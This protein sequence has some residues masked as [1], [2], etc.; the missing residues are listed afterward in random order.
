MKWLSFLNHPHHT[1]QQ[2]LH[3]VIV[4][5]SA[6]TLLLTITLVTFYYIQQTRDSLVEEMITVTKVIANNTKTAVGFNDHIDAQE[7]LQELQSNAAVDAVIIYDVFEEVFVQYARNEQI[8]IQIKYDQQGEYQFKGNHLYISQKIED[9]TGKLGEVHLQ[10]NLAKLNQQLFNALQVI[11]VIFVVSLLISYLLSLRLQKNISTPILKLAKV[12]RDIRESGNYEEYVELSDIAEIDQVREEFNA[13][14]DQISLREEGLKHLASHDVLTKLP[15]RAY[16]TEVLV[17]ALIRGMR[18]S[19][20]HAV[21][22]I[23]L[24]R[25]KNIND[26]LGHSAGDKLLETLSVRLLTVMRG[27]DLLARMGGD[28]FTILLQ[29]V[30][31]ANDAREIAVRIIDV[32]SK[33]FV[34]NDHEVVISPSIGIVMYPDHGATPE[35]LLKNADTAMYIAKSEGGNKYTFFDQ[36]MDVAAKKRMSIEESMRKGV[37]AGEFFLVYQPQISIMD[38]KITGFEALCR[39]QQD[40]GTFVSPVDFIPVAEETGLIID[41]GEMI[42]R[43]AFAQVKKWVESGLLTE[44]VA[45]NIS[46]KQFNQP[47]PGF[48]QLI[49]QLQEEYGLSSEFI[50]LEITEAVIMNQTGYTINLM[51]QLK[52]QGFKFSVDDFGTGYSSLTYLTKFPIDTLKIDMSFIKNLE[53]SKSQ[54]SIVQTIIDLGKNLSLGVIAE[55]VETQKQYEILSDMGCDSIQGYIFSRPLIAA[56]IEQLI[57]NKNYAN[58]TPLFKYLS[59][60]KS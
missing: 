37:A 56:E 3:L 60:T 23:D 29:E 53:F 11:V 45:I 18:K 5:V 19:H 8:N 16:F 39:W 7:V 2:R 51:N 4:F 32:L 46:P 57:C 43:E 1:I 38:K 30:T 6:V 22:F 55:G 59:N 42:L 31:H 47:D 35:A 15:N 41:I 26:S 21:L 58:V 27:E 48:F 34:I 33:P 20:I 52:K 50:E 54:R 13:L 40:D 9:E 10:A 14:L 25:F 44:H 49:S 12:T 36:S 17:S 28:E 24:D